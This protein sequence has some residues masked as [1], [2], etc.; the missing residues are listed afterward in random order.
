MT[1]LP[2]RMAGILLFLAIA[3]LAAQ[4]VLSV[5]K[6]NTS[7]QGGARL[8]VPVGNR[9]TASNV[10]VAVLIAAA[11]GGAFPLQESRIIGLP[12]WAA[13]ERFDVQARQDGVAV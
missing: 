2:R 8:G 4:E 3:P 7:G 12:P 5:I 13:R 1:R 10:S 6:P 9:F 11:Y